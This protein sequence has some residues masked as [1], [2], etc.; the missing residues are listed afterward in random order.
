MLCLHYCMRAFSS[1]SK[2]GLFLVGVSRL[3][4]VV[5]SLVAEHRLWGAQTWVVMAHALW[6][7]EVV[8]PR[9]MES[10]STGDHVHV[11]CI[12]W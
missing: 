2:W 6:H 9:H 8:A 4:I 11:F 7:M 12:G 10:C 3:L 1:C 5:A